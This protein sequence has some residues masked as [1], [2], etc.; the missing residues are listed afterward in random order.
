MNKHKT[1]FWRGFTWKRFIV[2]SLIF[3]IFFS[4]TQIVENLI[5]SPHQAFSSITLRFVIKV[6]LRSL[7]FGF[8]IS[9]WY[10]PGLDNRKVQKD[11]KA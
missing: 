5:E 4:V 11:A 2:N 3:I 10:E 1:G 8:F 7:V 9:L 6:L